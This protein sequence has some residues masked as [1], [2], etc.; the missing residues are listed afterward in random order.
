MVMGKEKTLSVFKYILSFLKWTA[1]GAS[2]GAIVGTAGAG[3]CLL[4]PAG[5]GLPHSS[6][7]SGSWTSSGGPSDLYFFTILPEQG[8]PRYESRARFY[9]DG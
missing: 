9:S 8:K 1:L 6:S 4:P 2:A 3:L 5:Y 7:P